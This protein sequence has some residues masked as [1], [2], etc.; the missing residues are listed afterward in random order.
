MALTELFELFDEV[1]KTCWMQR[2]KML[3]Q[4]VPSLGTREIKSSSSTFCPGVWKNHIAKGAIPSS[5]TMQLTFTLWPL[6]Y[7][8]QSSPLHRLLFWVAIAVL[9]LDEVSLYAAGLALLEQ[10]LH[11]LDEQ[12]VFNEVV[13]L[14]ALFDATVRACCTLSCPPVLYEPTS[15][16]VAITHEPLSNGGNQ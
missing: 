4:V 6:F 1:I 14:S 8:S 5:M 2:F 10:N 15:T 3:R 13:S 16:R 11:T 12:G 7:S 9:Q